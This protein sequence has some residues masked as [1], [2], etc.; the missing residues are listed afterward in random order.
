MKKKQIESEKMAVKADGEAMVLPSLPTA[1]RNEKKRNR[2]FSSAL[3]KESLHANR[4]GLAVVSIGNAIIMV[5]IISIL[6]TLHINATSSALKDL[7]D[8]ADY[9][10]TV[11]SGAVSLY[12][13]YDNA[14]TAYE[15]FIQGDDSAKALFE[16]EVKQVEDETLNSS[17]DTAKKLYDATYSVTP[18]EDAS[19]AAVAKAATMEVVDKTL[20]VIPDYSS[21]EKAIA[22]SIIS[23]YFDIY[24]TDMSKET[25]EILKVAIPLSFKE[26]VVTAYSISDENVIEGISS[27]LEGAITRVY[28]KGENVDEVKTESSFALLPLLSKG[29]ETDEFVSGACESLSS[30]YNEDKDLYVKDS[31]LRSER[32]SVLCEEYVSNVLSSFAYYQYLPSFTVE[33]KTNDLGWPVRL[34]GTGKYAD[35]GN[36]IKEEV[37]VKVYNPDVF[38]KEDEK[39]GK[40][41]NTV[42]KMRKEALTGIPYTEEEIES[43]KKEAESDVKM[44]Q[45]RLSGFMDAYTRRKD[46]KNR[47]YDENGINREG[48][49]SLAIEE[50]SEMSKEALINA[51]NEKNDPDI[52]SIEEITVENSSMSGREMMSLVKGYASGGISAYTT[53]YSDFESAGY[54]TSEC[55]LLALNKA[56]QGVMASLPTSV[57]DSLV[58]MGEMNTYGII[59]GVVAFGIAA[60]L[61]PMVYTILLSKSLVSEKVETGSL[62]FT[63]STPTTRDS[64]VFTQGCYLVFSEVVMALSLLLFSILARELGILAGSTDLGVSLPVEDICLYAFGNFMVTLAVSGI[65]FLAS[66]HFNKTSQSIGMGGGITIFFFVCSILGLFATQ[67]IPGTIRITSMSIFNYMTIDSLFDALAVMNGDY[68]LYFFKLLFLLLIAV[69]TYVLGDLDFRK[70]DLPL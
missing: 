40:T 67:A 63:L 64:F 30:L 6:S 10:T 35:N 8:N 43:A 16:T 55:N 26:A 27:L 25:K 11:K 39:M 61:V 9:E 57:N 69:F 20:D 49:A 2:L 29:T 1:K 68:G 59:V 48:I 21:E 51:Y 41:S 23:N 37:A 12:S 22:K 60:L 44:I 34:V 17:I 45:E 15:S 4:G 32:L 50:V 47:F 54:S 19:K 24:A 52:S 46:G 13:T 42:Q 62:A 66:C 28:D 70:K 56:S 36:E 7:F 53:Y 5:I 14:A 65:N 38:V 33:Y 31:S 58:E 3:F 18:G